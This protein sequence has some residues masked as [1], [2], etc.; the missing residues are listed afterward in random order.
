MHGRPPSTDLAAGL[1]M[2]LPRVCRAVKLPS[3]SASARQVRSA[4]SSRSERPAPIE[5]R[6]QGGDRR[7]KRIEAHC[8]SDPRTCG[9]GTQTSP[10]SGS[11]DAGGYGCRVGIGTLWRFFHRRHRITR[12]KR[13]PTRRKQ[14]PD[15]LKRRKAWFDGQLDLDPDHRL[16]FIDETR[17]LDQDQARLYGR[18]PRGGTLVPAVPHGRWKT[19][20]VT[21]GLRLTG[22]AGFHG[23]RRTDDR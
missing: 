5:P 15:I 11:G 10:L 3:G 8:A 7:S 4:G 21:A 13:P 12:K 20:T 14:A 18:A 23:A 6:M 22:I 2:P 16:V 1:S 19:T 9:R 17:R